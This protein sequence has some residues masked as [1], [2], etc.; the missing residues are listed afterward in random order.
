LGISGD[1]CRIIS[2]SSQTHKEGKIEEYRGEVVGL[3]SARCP[4]PAAL[5]LPAPRARIIKAPV[6]SP[7]AN[8]IAE[9]WIASACR[10]CLDRLLITGERHLRL[11]L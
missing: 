6:Q 1:L 11:V 7:R 10:K 4:R 3:R 2:K 8:A 9:R 5:D